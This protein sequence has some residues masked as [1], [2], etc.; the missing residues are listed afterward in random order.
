MVVAGS[1]GVISMLLS[2]MAVSRGSVVFLFLSLVFVGLTYGSVP[3]VT[4]GYISKSYGLT[5]FSINFSIANTMLI[6]S[7]FAAT[8]GGLILISTGSFVP[9]FIMLLIFA[10]AALAIALT[11]GKLKSS[12]APMAAELPTQD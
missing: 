5:H 8:V 7:S 1:A 10:V 4:A 12:A 6:I 9:V 3:T 11:M 2:I